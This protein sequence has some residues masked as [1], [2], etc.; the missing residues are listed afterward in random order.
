MNSKIF[1]KI[2]SLFVILTTTHVY[3]DNLPDSLFGVKMFD[4]INNYEV[5][6][7]FEHKFRDGTRSRDYYVLKNV[8]NPNDAFPFYSAITNPDDDK[9]VSVQGRI[10]N[11]EDG[12]LITTLKENPNGEPFCFARDLPKYVTAVSNAWQI[13]EGKFS[14]P[15]IRY[16]RKEIPE[17]LKNGFRFNLVRQLNFKKNKINMV[18]LVRCDYQYFALGDLIKFGGSEIPVSKP[19]ISADLWIKIMTEEYFKKFLP[20]KVYKNITVGNFIRQLSEG[21]STQGF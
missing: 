19:F 1:K 8:P 2:I 21:V 17:N 3:A 6:T 13:R 16:Y 15:E 11:I 10:K 18:A 14:D 5:I 7:K 12:T 9:I 4:S 20:T